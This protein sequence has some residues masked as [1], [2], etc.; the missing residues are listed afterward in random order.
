MEALNS[1]V[2]RISSKIEVGAG[3]KTI[4]IIRSIDSTNIRL[5]KTIVPDQFVEML[6][7][8]N[9][10]KKYRF[11]FCQTQPGYIHLILKN[12]PLLNE[13]QGILFFF[14][15]ELLQYIDNKQLSKKK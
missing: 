15:R 7:A 12:Q 6:L 10:R 8:G 5:S 2:E 14:F 11:E 9:E 3:V 4:K 13:G 1:Y